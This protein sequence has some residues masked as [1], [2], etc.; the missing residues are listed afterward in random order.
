MPLEA[1]ADPGDMEIDLCSVI[2][3]TDD[4]DK[5]VR[6]EWRLENSATLYKVYTMPMSQIGELGASPDLDLNC[7]TPGGIP[8]TQFTIPDSPEDLIFLV[9]GVFSGIEGTYGDGEY[10]PRVNTNPC[11]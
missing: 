4:L 6:V 7:Q 5:K 10:G 11:P 8:N 2:W 3:L 1:G 9:T